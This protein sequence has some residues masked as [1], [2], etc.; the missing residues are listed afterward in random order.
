MVCPSCLC[1]FTTVGPYIDHHPDQ[2]NKP[3]SSKI[4]KL[5]DR[6]TVSELA[7]LLW[8]NAVVAELAKLPSGEKFSNIIYSSIVSLVHNLTMC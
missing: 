4:E 5:L 1:I 3:P 8:R 7:L 6:A 2:C